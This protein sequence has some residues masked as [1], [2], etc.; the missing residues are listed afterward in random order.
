VTLPTTSEIQITVLHSGF[1]V[2]VK[3]ADEEG[4][5]YGSGIEKSRRKIAASTFEDLIGALRS[6]L[7][8]NADGD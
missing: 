2:E 6:A 5:T 7:G 1:L 3:P 4:K 8:L